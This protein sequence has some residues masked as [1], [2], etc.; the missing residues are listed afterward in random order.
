M[1]NSRWSPSWPVDKSVHFMCGRFCSDRGTVCFL[2]SKITGKNFN[3]LLLCNRHIF[4]FFRSVLQLS[5][6]AVYFF[7]NFRSFE[8]YVLLANVWDEAWNWSS[9]VYH[10]GLGIWSLEYH[11]TTL[12]SKFL[13]G[14]SIHGDFS[15]FFILFLARFCLWNI[16]PR[17]LTYR[18]R[19]VV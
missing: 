5:L 1:A 6:S 4:A 12:W 15:L 2:K 19:D 7:F 13:D 18:I 3:Y 8:Y 10:T 17:L 11:W 14:G 9:A 16:S